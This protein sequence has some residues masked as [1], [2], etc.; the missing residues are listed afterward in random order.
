MTV[1]TGGTPDAG[2]VTAL[3]AIIDAKRDEIE[4]RVQAELVASL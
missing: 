4:K 2:E 3:R 1:V